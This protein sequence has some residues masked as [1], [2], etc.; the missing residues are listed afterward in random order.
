MTKD[1]KDIRKMLDDFSSKMRTSANEFADLVV[2][3]HVQA[4]MRVRTM[5]ASAMT[6]KKRVYHIQCRMN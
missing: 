5:T 1:T 4:S 2:P 3:K 6:T